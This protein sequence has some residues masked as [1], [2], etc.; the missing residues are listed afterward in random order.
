M[1]RPNVLLIQCDQ[2]T[3]AVM[4][5]SRNEI[6]DAP[7]LRRLGEE[8]VTFERAYCPSPLC[9]PSRAAMMT[10]LLPSGN[11]AYDNAGDFPSSLPTIAHYLRRAGYRTE[12][13]GK[14][15]FI[16][17]DQLHG[18]EFRPT[19]DVYPAGFDWI[20]DW[21]TDERSPWYHDMSSVFR[22][23][24]V[25]A[26]L[27]ID[28]DEETGHAAGRALADAA[29][30]KRP[31]FLVASFTFPHDPFEVPARYWERYEGVQ[32]DDPIVGPLSDP[33]P[34]TRRLR[35]MI[36]ADRRTPSPEETRAARRGYYG[37]VSFIDDLLGQ[38][39]A[40]L[41]RLELTEN[42]VVIFT[43]DH[44]EMLGERGLWYKMA[45]FEGSA[46]V[47]LVIWNPTRFAPR[48]M[49]TGVSTLDLLPTLLELTGA[50]PAVTKLDGE[51][52]VP[53]LEGG[54][55]HGPV[56][57]EYLAE[58]VRAP[59]VMLV[60]G[61]FK[62]IRCPGDPDLLYDLDADPLETVSLAE[63]SEA[64]EVMVRMGGM[65]E[66]KWDLAE[67]GEQVLASQ[68]RRR[69]VAAANATGTVT[70]WDHR[71]SGAKYIGT[72]DDFWSTLESARLE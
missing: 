35:T 41:Q 1:D 58:G 4:P 16:G 50:G 7:N 37:A 21:T 2:M 19:S 39:L 47:P 52:L 3:R 33:D 60:D 71:P 10:G 56:A 28:F 55:G 72:G 44:G 17:P 70:T 62:L 34:H 25:K 45:P 18:F 6:V 36:E 26:A 38:L 13:A 32:I 51:S 61:R 8:G 66:S 24:P 9:V 65:I 46:G 27:Q 11:G 40:N 12:L 57:M 42:T 43:S 23:G 48:T 14:M 69:V 63:R 68:A 30:E 54:N 49:G 59:M 22:A 53:L 64:A 67:L 29:R 20:P 15:H 5:S 31:F